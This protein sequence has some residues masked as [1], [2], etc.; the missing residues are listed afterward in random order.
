MTPHKPRPEGPNAPGA[1]P[2]D[3]LF[4]DAIEGERARVLWGQEAFDMP[5]RLLPAGTREGGWLRIS[6]SPAPAPPDEGA[7]L[8][9]KLI[10]GDDGGDIKL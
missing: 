3:L 7:A 1:A 6:L 9:E 4:V 5:A 8:R 2:P 10:R